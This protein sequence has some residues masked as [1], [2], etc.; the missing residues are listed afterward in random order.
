MEGTV[1]ARGQS[2]TGKP[3]IT[4]DGKLYYAGRTDLA[5]LVSGDRLEFTATAFGDRGNLYGIDKGWKLV[6]GAQRY[7]QQPPQSNGIASPS[8][9]LRPDQVWPAPSVGVP[10]NR[11]GAPVQDSE[12]P[13]ISNWIAAAIAAGKIESCVD[14]LPWVRAAKQA[15]REDDEFQTDK[16]IPFSAT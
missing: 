4:I 9:P 15:L 12:R 11:L 2:K 7:P 3:T 13:A 5:G 16:D 6:Q 1:T 14:I 10:V 8:A